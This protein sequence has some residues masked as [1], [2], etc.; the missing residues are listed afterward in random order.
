[1]SKASVFCLKGQYSSVNQSSNINIHP[2]NNWRVAAIH[3]MNGTK[4]K[5]RI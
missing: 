4:I 5:R 1:M 2:M 3:R